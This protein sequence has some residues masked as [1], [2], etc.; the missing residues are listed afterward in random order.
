MIYTLG[1]AAK[2]TGYTKPT[3]KTAIENGKLSADR[4]EKGHYQIT[5]SEL[6]RVYP[7]ELLKL[8]TKQEEIR[9]DLRTFTP[10]NRNND[11]TLQVEVEI[12]RAKLES[13]ETA[14]KQEKE[15]LERQVESLRIERDRERQVLSDQVEDLRQQR[16]DWKKQASNQ[17]LLLSHEQERSK[18]LEEPPQGFFKKIFGVG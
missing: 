18:K 7:E 17:T 2:A 8:E 12:L 4:N 3:I 11:S 1:T 5:R 13:M 6:E 16:E 10:E 9:K 15:L 14:S